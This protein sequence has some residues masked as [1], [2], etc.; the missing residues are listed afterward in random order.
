MMVIDQVAQGPKK[1]IGDTTTRKP[2]STLS[3]TTASSISRSRSPQSEIGSTR[4]SSVE[5]ETDPP[6]LGKRVRDLEEIGNDS[7]KKKSRME[8]V[9]ADTASDWSIALQKLNK[10]KVSLDRQVQCD[11]HVML[12]P[13]LFLTGPGISQ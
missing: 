8:E 12:Q 4:A 10:G 5:V 9:G 2:T 13:Y 6:P 11:L 3:S 7:M 1:A